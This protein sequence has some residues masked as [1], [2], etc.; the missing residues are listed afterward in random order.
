LRRWARLK[1]RLTRVMLLP[2]LEAV[3][4]DLNGL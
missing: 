1:P 4:S 3:R 2:F